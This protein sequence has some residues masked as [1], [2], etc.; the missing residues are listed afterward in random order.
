MPGR[1]PH[2]AYRAFVTP[3]AAA[4]ACVAAAKIQPSAGG[5]TV[6]HHTH[7]LH[8]TRQSDTDYARLR[9]NPALELRARMVYRLIE[10]PR[11][12]YGPIR[13]TTKAYD[14]SLRLT[15]GESVVDYHWHPEG[16][17]HER[18]PHLHL[19]SAQLRKDG[20]IGRK[21]HLITGRVTFESV[22]RTAIELGAE[23]LQQDWAERLEAAEKP[24]ILHRSWG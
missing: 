13:A 17:S 18:L 2:E 5:M 12:G 20:V 24:H 11:L 22:I 16:R 9:G 21:H 6:L 10:D 3:L 14:Y 8:L 4:L 15:T 7:N 1:T 19:G 23:P